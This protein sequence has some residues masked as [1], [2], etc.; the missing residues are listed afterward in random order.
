[1]GDKRT[2]KEKKRRE[3]RKHK[4]KKT[5]EQPLARKNRLQ[6]LPVKRHRCFEY[7][8]VVPPSS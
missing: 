3:A 5:T 1:M 8:N 7:H 6:Y 2:G 4:M